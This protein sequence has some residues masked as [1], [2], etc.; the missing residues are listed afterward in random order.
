MPASSPLIRLYDR[1]DGLPFGRRVF[2][3]AYQAAAPYFLTI[4]ARVT[5]VA[6][7]EARA[8]MGHAPWVSNHL[9]TVHAIALCNLAEYT[10]GAVAEATVPDGYRWIPKGM[11]VDYLAKARGR[12]AAHAVLRLPEPLGDAQEVPVQVTVR[13]PAAVPVFTAQIRIWIT[14]NAPKE[15]P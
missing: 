13:D 2:S 15:T 1:L 10:M 6:P 12:M 8:E 9:G 5:A 7:G 3:I 14:T 11:S 4:P